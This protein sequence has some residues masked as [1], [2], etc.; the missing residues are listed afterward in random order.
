[1]TDSKVIK[2]TRGFANPAMPD[3]G[4]AMPDLGLSLRSP[5]TAEEVNGYQGAKALLYSLAIQIAGWRT[6]LPADVQP[7]V[8]ALLNGGH[9]IEV[10]RIGVESFHGIRIE[11]T[12]DGKRCVVFAH[13]STDQ[14]LCVAISAEP[15]RRPIG[16]V[17]PDG[18]STEA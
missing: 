3:L 12:Y 5:P 8:L 13:Q 9:R 14:L 11:G 2:A 16:F 17:W 6:Q 18:S 1:M 7:S 10:E 4:L 15:P